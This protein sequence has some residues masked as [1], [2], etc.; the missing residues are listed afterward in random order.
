MS[1]IKWNPLSNKFNCYFMHQIVLFNHNYYS[2]V[3]SG[4]ELGACQI[5]YGIVRKHAHDFAS[6][7]RKIYAFGLYQK[8]ILREKIVLLCML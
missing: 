3:H 7:R 6:R 8:K 4:P 5:V 1:V 2:A